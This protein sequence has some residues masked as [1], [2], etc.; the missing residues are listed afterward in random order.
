LR[1]AE[2]GRGCIVEIGQNGSSNRD[3]LPKQYNALTHVHE[4]GGASFSTRGSD[5]HIIV[6]DFDTNLVLDLDPATAKAEPIVE[7]DC[8]N[9]F[10]DFNVHPNDSKWVLAIRE[11]HHSNKIEDVENTLVA[12][13]SSTK[14]VHTIVSGADF[15]AYP[16]FSPDGKRLCWTQWNHP[17]MPW[18]CNELWVADWQ[19]GKV[20]NA[21]VVAGQGLK[22][23]IT[24]PQWG[25]DGS[26]FFVGDRT[27]FWQM[28]QFAGGSLRA[29][30]S[31]GLERA[32]FGA[33][34]WLLGR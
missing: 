8:K 1:P 11:D 28:Y 5:G 10:A 14:A 13:D 25:L 20:V 18:N 33:P 16:R 30:R 12:I 19:E 22:E 7:E 3:V 23:S 4:Y 2:G 26:L 24:Q 9:Y 21:G 17:N 27:G 31:K 34:E 32:E 6:S 15:Y 29:V